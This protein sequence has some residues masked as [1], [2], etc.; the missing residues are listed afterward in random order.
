MRLG[1]E[2]RL[3]IY[4]DGITEAARPTGEEY[5]AERLV[6]HLKAPDACLETLLADVRQFV[7]GAGLRDDATLI[8]VGTRPDLHL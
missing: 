1:P 6:A 7:D 4:S 2:S 5:G 3:A 8:L